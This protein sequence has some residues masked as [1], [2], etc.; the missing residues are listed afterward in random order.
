MENF[1]HSVL[2]K[3]TAGSDPAAMVSETRLPPFWRTPAVI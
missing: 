3:N 2:P 1:I